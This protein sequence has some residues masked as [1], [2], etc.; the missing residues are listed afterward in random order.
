[1]RFS[2]LVAPLAVVLALS[3]A[4]ASQEIDVYTVISDSADSADYT[5]I[6]DSADVAPPAPDDSPFAEELFDEAYTPVG[7]CRGEPSCGNFGCCCPCPSWC[8][9]GGT[10]L[11]DRSTHHNSVLV[12]RD[13]DPSSRALLRAEDFNFDV[14]GGFEASVIRRNVRCSCWDIEARYFRVDGW[15]AYHAG[16]D[17]PDGLWFQYADPL[18]TFG[19]AAY[20]CAYR[21]DLDGFEL[22]LRRPVDGG[23][24]TLVGGFRFVELDE[25]I[26]GGV[27][28]LRSGAVSTLYTSA[29]N[30]LYGFQLGADACIYCRGCFSID[31][32]ARAGVYGTRVA[33]SVAIRPDSATNLYCRADDRRTSF[34]GELGLTGTCRLVDRLNLTAGYRLTWLD[35]VA[36]APDQL[37]VSNPLGGIA[38][39]DTSGTPLYHGVVISLEYCR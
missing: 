30:D 20:G 1:M 17:A 23:W 27:R 12:T 36:L 31:G 4:V 28:D 34:V 13:P 33:T 7:G 32:L 8:I 9:E 15:E 21:S 2:F 29:I 3:A 18:G 35:K 22:N 24:L 26:H 14:R 11:L 10:L 25:R 5:V 16:G 38:T 39:V 6:S 37:A 19:P